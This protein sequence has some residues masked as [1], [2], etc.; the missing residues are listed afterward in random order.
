MRQAAPPKPP[1]PR[2]L[3]VVVPDA[4]FVA[5]ADHAIRQRETRAAVVARALAEYIER[6]AA[7]A[8]VEATP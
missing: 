8:T 3:N 2:Q 1:R 4:V 7:R 6:Q 5:I